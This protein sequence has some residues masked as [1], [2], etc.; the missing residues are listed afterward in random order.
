MYNIAM[1]NG[2]VFQNYYNVYTSYSARSLTQSSSVSATT[3]K[4]TDFKNCY[5]FYPFYNKYL[6]YDDIFNSLS[7]YSGDNVYRIY[8]RDNSGDFYNPD[9]IKSLSSRYFEV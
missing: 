1:I 8:K 7:T 9:L 4:I 3:R 5:N 6:K 2:N